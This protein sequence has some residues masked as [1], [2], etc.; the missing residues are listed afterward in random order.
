MSQ[1]KYGPMCT[2]T[3]TWHHVKLCR[4]CALKKTAENFALA[5]FS[6]AWLALNHEKLAEKTYTIRHLMPQNEAYNFEAGLN[7]CCLHTAKDELFGQNQSCVELNPPP[8]PLF[9]FNKI[10]VP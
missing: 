9:P 8:P 6:G 4:D 5:K 3:C 1:N 10:T 2:D 7:F